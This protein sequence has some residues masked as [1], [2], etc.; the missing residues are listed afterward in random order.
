MLRHEPHKRYRGDVPG[1][2]IG[3]IFEKRADMLVVCLKEN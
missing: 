1:C 3:Q 2:H